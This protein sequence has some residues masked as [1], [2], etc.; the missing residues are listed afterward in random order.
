MEFHPISIAGIAMPQPMKLNPGFR[1]HLDEQSPGF[2]LSYG[3]DFIHQPTDGLANQLAPHPKDVQGDENR[4]HRIKTR[5]A[6]E[7]G[8]TKPH[9]DTETGQAV[10]EYM[11][12]IGLNDHRPILFSNPD[13]ISAQSSV[14]QTS[15]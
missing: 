2:S 5:P 7:D 9:E 4:N 12:T 15:D 14:D 11:S 3:I 10:G 8:Q 13:E 1:S 6:R